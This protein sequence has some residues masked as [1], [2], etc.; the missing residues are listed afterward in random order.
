MKHAEGSILNMCP[1]QPGWRVVLRWV[2][3]EDLIIQ[4]ILGWATVVTWVSSEGEEFETKMQPVFI[5][6]GKFPTNEY[7]AKDD[8][9]LVSEIL[10]PKQQPSSKKARTLR[11]MESREE[12]KKAVF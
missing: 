11:E 6:E 8:G 5:I 7:W 9:I 10:Q 12:S 1:A 4:D 3:N 2:D